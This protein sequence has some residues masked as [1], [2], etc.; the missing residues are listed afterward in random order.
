MNVINQF[1]SFRHILAQDAPPDIF[2][3]SS[4]LC[5]SGGFA[6]FTTFFPVLL[7]NCSIQH[8]KVTLKR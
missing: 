5:L 6:Q 8:E 2:S 4:D 7:G 1:R 3:R